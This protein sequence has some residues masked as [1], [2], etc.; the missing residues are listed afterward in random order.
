S[1]GDKT[2][3]AL[4]QILAAAVIEAVAGLF[5]TLSNR[6]RTLLID[7][8]DK[9]RED[10]QFEEALMLARAL[11]ETPIKNRLHVALAIHLAKADQAVLNSVISPSD[12]EATAAPAVSANGKLANFEGAPADSSPGANAESEGAAALPVLEPPAI[13][14]TEYAGDMQQ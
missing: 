5:F 4:V 8:F 11:P 2:A 7:F 13:D 9:L 12:G 3:A 10:R 6:S 1:G 14:A